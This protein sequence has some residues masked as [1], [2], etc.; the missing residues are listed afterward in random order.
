MP[1]TP[2]PP[3]LLNTS[4]H[5]TVKPHRWTVQKQ[6]IGQTRN[7]EAR[8]FLDADQALANGPIRGWTT[9]LEKACRGRVRVGA[10]QGGVCC[11]G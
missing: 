2:S 10:R 5:E 7:E 8:P 6:S 1:I 3:E 11:C 4:P 9:G